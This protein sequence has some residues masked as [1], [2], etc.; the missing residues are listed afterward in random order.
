MTLWRYCCP[1]YSIYVTKQNAC[2]AYQNKYINIKYTHVSQKRAQVQTDRSN[3]PLSVK[4]YQKKPRRYLEPLACI[5]LSQE[6]TDDMLKIL[7]E[8][9]RFAAC[10]TR[11]T[12]L[13]AQVPPRTSYFVRYYPTKF[14]S[15]CYHR[16]LPSATTKKKENYTCFTPDQCWVMSRKSIY[17]TISWKR[18]SVRRCSHVL[19]RSRTGMQAYADLLLKHLSTVHAYA[20]ERSGHVVSTYFNK[21]LNAA[22]ILSTLTSDLMETVSSSLIVASSGC[23]T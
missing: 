22:S 11:F 10:N 23:T 7:S 16:I 1:S 14:G 13:P 19:H 18:K 17:E 5:D 3:H 15:L 21:R 8:A 20:P 6:P 12:W 2:T 9:H 4:I